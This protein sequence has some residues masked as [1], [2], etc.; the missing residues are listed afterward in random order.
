MNGNVKK[1]K[2]IFVILEW[3]LWLVG[4]EVSSSIH[5]FIYFILTQAAWPIK[6][7]DR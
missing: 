5:P 3:W 2:D 6:T 7:T 1:N 4:L